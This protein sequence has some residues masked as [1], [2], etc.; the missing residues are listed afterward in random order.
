MQNQSVSL[1]FI[2]G[3]QELARDPL[4]SSNEQYSRIKNEQSMKKKQEMVD[5]ETMISKQ[6]QMMKESSTPIS[7]EPNLLISGAEKQ[8]ETVMLQFVPTSTSTFEGKA[9]L[10]EANPLEDWFRKHKIKIN[11]QVLEVLNELGVHEPIDFKHLDEED[12]NSICALLTKIDGRKFR[13][14]LAENNVENV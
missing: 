1:Q 10:E 2:P 13:T 12:E 7:K 11:K 9:N 3:S 4:E 5:A 8:N 6:F 14:A